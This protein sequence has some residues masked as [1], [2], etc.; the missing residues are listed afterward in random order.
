MIVDEAKLKLLDE[1]ASLLPLCPN[2]EFVVLNDQVVAPKHLSRLSIIG[3]KCEDTIKNAPPTV[4]SE[5]YKVANIELY[6]V[7]SAG[8]LFGY[9]VLAL[10]RKVEHHPNYV[11]LTNV[12]DKS[13]A[14][15]DMPFQ[16]S[17]FSIINSPLGACVLV[18]NKTKYFNTDIIRKVKRKGQQ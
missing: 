17:Y 1:C 4:D 6:S 14:G 5:P 2:N 11:A 16:N 10:A 18:S 12:K 3:F 9:I 13:Y 15:V 8:L 7:K